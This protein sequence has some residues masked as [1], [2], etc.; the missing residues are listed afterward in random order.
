[1]SKKFTSATGGEASPG[2]IIVYAVGRQPVGLILAVV[3]EVTEDAM[4]VEVF[5]NVSRVVHCLETDTDAFN[6]G[7]GY[8][9]RVH[10]IKRRRATLTNP[11]FVFVD[12]MRLDSPAGEAAIT[13][14]CSVLCDVR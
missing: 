12:R 2:D 13:K 5:E 11:R 4:H 1:M 7:W 9:K 6:T 10:S 14:Q 3:L 8:R